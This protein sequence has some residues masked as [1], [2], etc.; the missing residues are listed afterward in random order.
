M[1]TAMR[2]VRAWGW[3]ALLALLAAPGAAAAQAPI[4][5]GSINSFSGLAAAF[6][7][8]ERLGEELAAE[9]AN[10][11]GGLLGGR[12]LV[13][14]P[15]DDKLRPD[16]G[17]KQA[18]EL[19]LQE[20]VDFLIGTLSSA[21]A[22]GVSDFAKR[23]KT[24]YVA[25]EAQTDALT[26]ER[27]HRYVFRIRPNTYMVGRA[28][29]ERAAKL[30]H[31]RWVNIGPNYEYGRKTWEAFITRLRE[32][33]P[34]VQVVAEHWPK[35][36]E[37]E[38]GAYINSILQARPDA[39]F[40][41]LFGAD[42]ANFVKQASAFEMF[43]KT[44]F[45][46]M[47]GGLP[48]FAEPLGKD[49]PDGMIVDAYPWQLIETPAHRAFVE[50]YRKKT[51][52]HPVYGSLIGYINMTVLI[53]AIKKAGTTE[54]E[55]VI[56]ALEGLTVSTPVGAVTLRADDHQSTLGAW[57]GVSRFDAARSLATVADWEYVPGDRHPPTRRWKDHWK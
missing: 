35:L 57:I 37:G 36:G 4:K 53:E 7:V 21:V 6:T 17:I 28:L 27:G 12:Q 38:Y 33:H 23:T 18:Q 50:A 40:T 8:P 1:T 31:R 24:L 11:A 44:F 47:A 26:W 29:A 54:V 42:W 25:G 13:V 52:A 22:L 34:D 39:V 43:G 3:L 16:E 56:D 55:K 2:R 51:G 20:K 45:V 46:A 10:A 19:V 9:Q 32:L 15:R 30:P 5:V 48:E 14:I 49:Q 41:S